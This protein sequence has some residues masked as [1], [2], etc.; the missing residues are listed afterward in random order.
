MKKV[1]GKLLYTGI[2]GRWDD[3]IKQ[4]QFGLITYVTGCI[5]GLLLALSAIFGSGS[6]LGSSLLG[7]LIPFCIF[8]FCLPFVIAIGGLEI[9]AIYE[10]GITDRNDNLFKR[11]NGKSFHRFEK[12]TKIGYGQYT[13][14]DIVKNFIIIYEDNSSLPT[15]GSFNDKAF[16]NDFYEKVVETLK[17]KCPNAKWKKVDFF[18]IPRSK[19]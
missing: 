18:S 7:F 9:D 1:R 19:R 10:N 4:Q 14:N 2:Q 17:E 13:W 3:T 12:I 6:I 5:V 16:K 15:C 11:L 8:L